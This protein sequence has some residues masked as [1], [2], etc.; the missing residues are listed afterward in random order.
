MA[1]TT[2][3]EVGKLSVKVSPDTSKFRRELKKQ[4]EAIEKALGKDRDL[5]GSEE[6]EAKV[7]KSAKK[8]SKTKFKL[9]VDSSDL[10]KEI[11]RLNKMAGSGS[12]YKLNVDSSDI[13]KQIAKLDNIRNKSV[14]ADDKS[15]RSAVNKMQ[16]RLDLLDL[17]WDKKTR[18]FLRGGT[19]EKVTAPQF[20]AAQLE[21]E[22]QRIMREFR[23]IEGEA[24]KSGDRLSQSMATSWAKAFNPRV[25]NE[26][27]RRAFG[28][29]RKINV[30]PD[31]GGFRAEVNAKTKGMRTS[32]KVDPD[33]DRGFFKKIGD[34][35]KKIP[36]PSFGSGINPA[37]YLVIIGLIASLSP[38]ILGL[39][40]AISTAVLAIPGLLALVLAPIGA[41]ALGIDGIKKAAE[42]LKQPFQ[43]LKKV[44]SS[45]VQ[46]Q[47]TPVFEKLRDVFPSLQKTLPRITQ[48]MA[49]M[50][51]AMVDAITRPENLIT[52]EGIFTDIGEAL[53]KMAPGMGDFTTGFL[54]LIKGFTGKL[55]DLADW[56]NETGASF[57]T[58][59][60]DFTEKGPDGTSQF[61]RALDGLGFTL[62]ELGGGLVELAGKTIDFLSDP[63]KVETFKRQLE[64]LVGLVL[65]IADALTVAADAMGKL[66]IFKNGEGNV[67]DFL[68]APIQWIKDG[69]DEIDFS[70]IWESLK[71]SASSAWE[72]VKGV[73]API[74]SFFSSVF[75][76]I[77]AVVTPVWNVIAAA[78][79]TTYNVI[80]AI[81]SGFASFFAGIWS[82][83]A[84]YAEVAWEAIKSGAS[85]AWGVVQSVWAPIAS[86]FS[87]VWSA[88]TG[89][90]SSAWETFK[91]II[92]TASNEVVNIITNLGSS[93][94][95]TIE[96]IDLFSAGQAIIQGLINGI[97]SMVDAVVGAATNVASSIKNAVTGFL[98]INSPS[99]VFAEI[100][101][102]TASGFALGLKNGF[103]P[104]LEQA[105]AM[106]GQVA[107]AFASGADPTGI[108]NGFAQK[109]IDR[110]EKV[111]ALESKRLET[112]AK[113]LDYQAKM[114]G[115]DALKER[116][117][118]IRLQ[119]DQIQLQKE[120]LGLTQDYSSEVGSTSGEDP[121]V[122][123]A[124]GLMN[125]PVD[126]AKATGKQFLSDLGIGGDGFISR[127]ITEGIQYVFQIGS[128]DEAL[129]IKDR[130][131]SKNALSMMGR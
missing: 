18:D 116:A 30:E 40:G 121:L 39:L 19:F 48:G 49:D 105:K 112:Q 90:V 76:Q 100:G 110:I 115:N 120:M 5:F 83:L 62:K 28:G 96:S 123:A 84:P 71:Q 20:E 108:L 44:M 122:K 31:L 21:A 63:E 94:V 77:G 130:E 59:I 70:G 69:F 27:I 32:V 16:K 113:A 23:Y 87:G 33:I 47:F 26:R 9:N 97:S 78:A 65:G 124:S 111:L 58:W 61:D 126:F 79:T 66:G 17:N 8:V 127:A 73:W 85:A 10:D 95:S 109:D 24:K 129:S 91:S 128:V 7:G 29:S 125:T 80:S 60:K 12:K 42:T 57:K 36:T 102:D 11:D 101:E 106:A 4:L 119:K 89:V 46:E 68:P 41:L 103:E 93:I 82:G 54:D 35:F 6:S 2:G 99:R 55:P 131:T 104:V 37:G 117:K 88:V 56:F 22:T 64:G 51:G 86:F 75:S 13:D 43:E 67:G 72:F 118:E 107:E 1:E 92:S 15:F 3:A 114:S 50:A 98:G 38:L 74:G 52:L 45:A 25:I 81:W 14:V 34:S 53:S